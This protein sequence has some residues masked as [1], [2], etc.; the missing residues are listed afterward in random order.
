MIDM[1]IFCAKIVSRRSLKSSFASDFPTCSRSSAIIL[2]IEGSSLNRAIEVI[3]S[4]SRYHATVDSFSS[5]PSMN[6][7][8][9]PGVSKDKF[10]S[11]RRIPATIP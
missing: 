9:I 7:V 2:L 5:A 6:P 3:G 1:K 8:S 4:F 10:S 11:A